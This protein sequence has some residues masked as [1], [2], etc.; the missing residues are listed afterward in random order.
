MTWAKPVSVW[1]W[2]LLFT[3]AMVSILALLLGALLGPWL[4]PN[5]SLEDRS[6]APLGWGLLGLQIALLMAPVLGF[7]LARNN[8]SHRQKVIAGTLCTL[9]IV[10]VNG[11]VA[12][13]GCAA[14]SA[15]VK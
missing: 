12:F 7:W 6:W 5:E 4:Y 8:E 3:P 13:A 10:V 2:L 14:A 11:F 1:Q 15:F 9:G